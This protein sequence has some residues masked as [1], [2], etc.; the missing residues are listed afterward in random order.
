MTITTTA[1]QTVIE[2][3]GVTTAFAF[4]F[5]A[6]LAT[7]IAVT[8]T[9]PD[10]NSSILSPSD[11]NL[12]LNPPASGQIWGVGGT[13]TYP[14]SGS[15][16]P[17]DSTLT[18]QRLMPLTQTTTISNQGTFYPQVVEAALDRLTM[19]I[20]QN[21][22]RSGLFRGTWASEV[23]YN[24]GDVVIDGAAGDDTGNYYL[25]A[26]SNVSSTWAAD[27]AAGD[28]TLSLDIQDL[29]A[30]AAEAAATVLIATSSTND[31]II[32]TG[33]QTLEIEAG[34]EFQEGMFV[35]ASDAENP[36]N[37]MIGQVTSYS[38][39]SLTF[40][41]TAT[42]GSGTPSSWN[43][44]VAG[45]PGPTGAQGPSGSLPIAAA[46]G[47]ANALTATWTG[48]TVADKTVG[49]VILGAAVTVTNP[50]LAVNGG[51]AYTI[52]ARGGQAL[53]IGDLP[54]AN[55]VAQIEYNAANTRW[56]LLNPAPNP[57]IA[58]KT[59]L[60]NTSGS[61]APSSCFTS[62]S[63]RISMVVS[64]PPRPSVRAA[65]RMLHANG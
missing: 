11:Y 51:T 37:Y 30:L 33:S 28:W 32:G 45:S 12:V 7:N 15:P 20:Q 58:S 19:L 38:G 5:V 65:S 18:I 10:G 61:S 17:S 26:Q 46:G 24:T 13:V 54:A 62:S 29:L 9:D 57:P 6:G 23:S 8:Y 4:S 49:L 35:V 59:L 31:V 3:N 25:C 36:A 39:T 40:D 16:I 47:T 55:F 1:S 52:T 63:A 50:T 42:G 48:I 2:G 34:K 53:Q 56:E 22:A 14:L 60:A 21:A 44:G 27:L 64:T 43:V 41:V